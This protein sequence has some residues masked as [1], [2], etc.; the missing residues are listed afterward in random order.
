[1][2]PA[3]SNLSRSFLW[4]EKAREQGINLD[5]V[6]Y[7]DKKGTYQRLDE[8]GLP[9]S[10]TEIYPCENYMNNLDSIKSFIDEGK[11]IFCRINPLVKGFPRFFSTNIRTFDDF[12]KFMNS[13]K[14]NHK[15]YEIHL[16]QNGEVTHAGVIISS[17]R[18]IGEIIEG[19]ST[20]L[21]EG[22]SEMPLGA[23]IDSFTG[24]ITFTNKSSE[25]AAKWLVKAM[26]LIGAQQKAIKGYFE[27]QV[28]NGRLVFINCQTKG[29]FTE[30]GVK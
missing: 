7:Q 17:D 15:Q 25:K 1:M 20:D 12:T 30:L 5:E 22:K 18:I 13:H 23:E 3:N 8:L 14:F 10:K 28:S 6:L 26:K 24:R 2:N 9:H 27:F 21:H 11:I 16:V 19:T 29:G 4:K